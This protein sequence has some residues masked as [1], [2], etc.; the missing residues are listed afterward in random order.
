[1]R[2]TSRKKRSSFTSS[3]FQF[4]S[5]SHTSSLLKGLNALRNK[6]LLLDVT[7]IAGG[8]EFKAH[9]VVL[10]SCSEYFRAMFTD[11]MM[12]RS[13]A[14]IYLNGVS[15]QGLRY[16][17]EY[18]YTSRLHLNLNN[19]QDV[20]SAA[21]H[22]Q[23]IPVV[24][25]CS[26]FLQSQLDLDNCVDIATIAE[27]YSLRQLQK[28]VYQYMCSNLNHFC[29]TSRFQY[30]TS[31]QLEYLLACDY[32]VDC[33]ETEVLS[34]LIRWL[35]HDIKNRIIYSYKLLNH[36]HFTQLSS[37]AVSHFV[38]S[39]LF[40]EILSSCSKQDLKTLPVLH[41]QTQQLQ[42][43][44]KVHDQALVNTRGMELALMKVGGFSISG[45]TNEVTYFLPSVGK[46]RYLTSI[47]H[48]EQCN[49][50]TTVL[51][52]EL[53]VIGGC[54]N[55]SLQENIHPF[56]FVYNP[57]SNSWTTIAPMQNE[58]CRF[59]LTV[60]DN[61]LFAVGGVG[62]N[63]SLLEENSPCEVYDPASDSWTFIPSLPGW[64]SQ[65][66]GCS[67]GMSLFVSGGLDQDLV[68]SSFLRY[69][70]SNECWE[71]CQSMLTP[72]ADHIM[73]MYGEKLYVCGGWYEDENSG[74]RVL[75]DT[76][77]CYDVKQNEWTVVTKVP[78]PRYHA[79]I[80]TVEGVIYVMGGFHSDATFDRASG[81]IE[82]YDIDGNQW[83]SMDKYPH[84]VW[85]HSC[86]T[87]FVPTCR[88]DLDVVANVVS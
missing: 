68:L 32:P 1:M 2:D 63:G 21:S 45:V 34:A 5:P 37:D 29:S 39:S 36:I 20:L 24:E 8:H 88:D 67:F 41:H 22:V 47:P 80:V 55:Q 35:K 86:C 6:E 87:L 9:R 83:F 3:T 40:K 7:L 33:P 79:G 17:L 50:G 46:W 57:S 62:E 43:M 74:L 54:F 65:H 72:R 30:L 75:A 56:G 26:Q 71:H 18:A 15:A 16:I 82:C 64:R 51:N 60:V 58:R 19:I 42:T 14:E 84:E 11:A 49:F 61:R 53:Y 12:E 23:L 10:A 69:D 48:V 81:V 28:S 27:T 44:N 77:D 31:S 85:E 52:N 76:I 38:E 13:L 25:T 59:S 70:V 78:T 73:V 66:A 4:E